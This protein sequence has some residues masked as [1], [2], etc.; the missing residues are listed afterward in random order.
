MGAKGL[1]LVGAKGL[2]DF[3]A[4]LSTVIEKKKFVPPPC[5]FESSI[6][7]GGNFFPYHGI[8]LVNFLSRSKTVC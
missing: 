1:A 8:N 3:H 5:D 6:A 2:T 7:E 4:F